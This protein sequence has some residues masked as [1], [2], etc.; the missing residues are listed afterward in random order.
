MRAQACWDTLNLRVHSVV[1]LGRR[2]G[3][4]H[5]AAEGAAVSGFFMPQAPGYRERGSNAGG[6]RSS[7]GREAGRRRS[8]P[9]R[10]SCWCDA[11]S[12]GRAVSAHWLGDIAF[13]DVTGADAVAGRSAMVCPVPPVSTDG[14]AAPATFVL[15]GDDGAVGRADLV[16]R[17]C[18]NGPRGARGERRRARVVVRWVRATLFCE[19]S[20]P[21]DVVTILM[22]ASHLLRDPL[23]T[24]DRQGAGVAV[25]RLSLTSVS[26]PPLCRS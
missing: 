10:I 19:S 3:T 18:P 9:R 11:R 23:V 17:G 5:G 25:W 6:T 1:P 13:E 24:R 12:G 4:S 8:L 2:C 22:C 16:E 21:D 14:W 20:A 7:F 15:L 26:S